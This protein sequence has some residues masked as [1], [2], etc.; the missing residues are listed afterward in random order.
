MSA[1]AS[2]L[3]A[4]VVAQ[5]AAYPA[6]R[7]SPPLGLDLY[8]PVPEDNPLTPE[9]AR[10][11]RRLFADGL[12]SRDG[13]RACVTCH[14][15][16]RAFTDGRSVA[17]GVRGQTGERSAPTLVN[18]GY[19]RSYFWDGRAPSLE[20]Q[21]LEPIANPKELDLAIDEAVR[22]LARTRAYRRQFQTAFGRPVNA[23]DLAR[24]LASYMRSILSGN[25]PLDRY[26]NG[27][28]DA[29]SPQARKGLDIFRGK[30]N[31]TACHVGPTLSDEQFHNTGVAWRESAEMAGEAGGAG[32]AG[33]FQD[34]GRAEITR[35]PEDRGAFKTPTLREVARTAPYMHDGSF[36]TLGEVL[37]FYDRG[38][39]ANPFLDREL[40]PLDLSD[41][42]KR[43]LLVFLR[44]LNGDISEGPDGSSRSS[45]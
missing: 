5:A 16:R 22:R 28:R 21:V 42:E 29:L 20:V 9:K 1:F 45:M 32:R 40:R 10:L 36:A 24:S 11:G 7:K 38:G 41:D 2:L 12:L 30:G 34:E 43:A 26:M 6:V 17:V 13:T 15:P 35:R 37:E 18:R 8:M 4:A 23:E 44:S 14:D 27:E 25:S 3:L 39:R 31:C 33:K 19:G